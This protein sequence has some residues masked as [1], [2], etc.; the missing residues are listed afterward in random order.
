MTKINN[1]NELFMLEKQNN[2]E[3]ES[4]YFK[5]LAKVKKMRQNG[6][7]DEDDFIDDFEKNHASAITY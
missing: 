3:S 5:Q 6:E 2:L 4:T 7:F 1:E